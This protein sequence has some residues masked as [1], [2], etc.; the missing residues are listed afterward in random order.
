[1]ER[2][3]GSVYKGVWEPPFFSPP[4][5]GHTRFAAHTSVSP[6]IALP[7]LDFYQPLP[8]PA[9]IPR[10]VCPQVTRAPLLPFFF[11]A[12][13]Y[14]PCT[15]CPLPILCPNRL[16]CEF[17]SMFFPFFLDI[18][19]DYLSVFVAHG[20]PFPVSFYAL[21]ISPPPS[22]TNSIFSSALTPSCRKDSLVPFLSS[23]SCF[24][25]VF[26]TIQPTTLPCPLQ[27][28]P[29]DSR[30]GTYEA[31]GRYFLLH[32]IYLFFSPLPFFVLSLFPTART[33]FYNPFPSFS[34]KALLLSCGVNPPLN[35]SLSELTFSPFSL[36]Y[37]CMVSSPWVW[38]RKLDGFFPSFASVAYP[39]C[40]Q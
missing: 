7:T 22:R 40:L 28:R 30:I 14:P 10:G 16:S 27:G 24:T 32:Y 31:D 25:F 2:L 18:V 39:M 3:S 34:C 9:S 33:N 5:D 29:E 26:D 21:F 13:N 36:S 38:S 4:I 23:Q 8:H 17:P 19:L 15:G 6:R 11:L 20:L 12:S 37:D 35:P 1:L